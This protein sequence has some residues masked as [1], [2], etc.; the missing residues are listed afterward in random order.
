[1]YI[2]KSTLIHSA[3]HLITGVTGLRAPPDSEG[4]VGPIRPRPGNSGE[5]DPHRTRDGGGNL[6]VLFFILNHGKFCV[7]SKAVTPG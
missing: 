5:T 3:T 1:M 7:M 6:L 2:A 4:A